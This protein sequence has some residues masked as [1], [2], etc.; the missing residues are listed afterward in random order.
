MRIGLIFGLFFCVCTSLNAQIYEDPGK[1]YA[2]FL[3]PKGKLIQ[4]DYNYTYEQ[5]PDGTYLFK[6]YYPEKK[7]LIAL[8]RYSDRKMTRL[9]GPFKLWMDDGS[10]LME[11]RYSKNKK[12]GIWTEL[13]S[14]NAELEK[15]KYVYGLRE[16]LWV[17][18]N[19]KGDTI[20][21]N[22]YKKGEKEGIEEHFDEKGILVYKAMHKDDE[23]EVLY[24]APP[25]DASDMEEIMP[26]FPGC[27]TYVEMDKARYEACATRKFLEFIYGNVNYPRFARRQGVEGFAM[28]KFTISETGEVENIETI[29]GLCDA[30]DKEGH[31]LLGSMPTWFPGYQDG[32]PV[33]VEFYIP[34]QFKLE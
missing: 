5:L 22:R 11:G 13:V 6:Q 29:R 2:E 14:V 16:G 7:L 21:L 19:M 27:E 33:P 12:V 20:A 32:K 15:G 30:I 18:T 17:S 25:E 4:A 24:L 34:I 26:Q 8:A 10:I 23:V 28:F 9:E 3:E 1:Y 31:R